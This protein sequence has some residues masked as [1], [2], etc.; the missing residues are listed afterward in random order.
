MARSILIEQRIE[1]KHAALRYRRA[2]RNERHLAEI[3]SSFV[4][5][6][7]VFQYLFAPVCPGFHYL[8]VFYSEDYAIDHRAV[9]AERLR[10][11]DGAVHACSVREREHLFRRDVRREHDARAGLLCSAAPVMSFR[12]VYREICACSVFIS[13]SFEVVVIEDVDMSLKLVDMILPVLQG[14]SAVYSAAREDIIPQPCDSVFFAEIREHQPCPGL[15]RHRA[16]APRAVAAHHFFT[17]MSQ[18]LA[19]AY[20]SPRDAV[21]IDSL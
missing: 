12:K 14:I 16:D 5:S 17:V 20:L 10:G 8:S 13:E 19:A 21:R 11:N 15:R 9:V 3:R 1:E 18:R 4:D 7:S 2:V 6:D